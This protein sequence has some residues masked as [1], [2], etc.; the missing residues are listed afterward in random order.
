MPVGRVREGVGDG[1]DRI[2]ERVGTG[3]WGRV[4]T[5]R[6]RDRIREGTG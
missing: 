1:R 3:G 6:G 2:R 5:G 4:G